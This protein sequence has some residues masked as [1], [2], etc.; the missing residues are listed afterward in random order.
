MLFRSLEGE[1]LLALHRPNTHLQERTVFIQ[2]NLP[3]IR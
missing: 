3:Q 1:V 2:P